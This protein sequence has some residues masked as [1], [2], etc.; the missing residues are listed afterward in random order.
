MVHVSPIE[1]I[2]VGRR[3]GARL[4]LDDVSLSVEPRTICVL[5]GPNGSG[6]TT[7]LK[8]LAGL[9]VPTTGH[10]RLLGMDPRRRRREVMRRAR[11]AFAP[12]ALYDTLTGWEHLKHLGAL[13]ETD[14][15][16]AR[17]QMQ[18]ALDAVDLADR[19]HDRVR[20]YSFG[21]RQRLVLALGL[22][23][24]PDV[25]LLDEPTDGLDPLAILELRRIVARL[26]DEHGIT[27]LLSSHQ[28]IELE[29]L[30]DELVVLNEGRVRFAGS[31]RQLCGEG[32]LR[33]E[34]PDASAA[35]ACLRERRLDARVES[36]TELSLPAGS[37]SLEAARRILGAAGIELRTFAHRRRP[38][39]E[40]LLEQ[41]R[42][43]TPDLN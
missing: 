38:L 28:L 3:F 22:V 27:I 43:K 20:T 40:A 13:G 26:R 29:H 30:A 33:I 2:R 41:L 18:S 12:P 31:P 6:K 42:G 36:E 1:L 10:A 32:R 4:A 5:A 14:R 9:L 35:A 37:I 23:P 15:R 25:L 17:S 11:F 24:R 34:V 16:G 7:L 19:A 39:H 21:M 8:I